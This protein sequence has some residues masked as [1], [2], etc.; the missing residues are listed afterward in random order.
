MS[1]I[2]V[3]FLAAVAHSVQHTP[4]QKRLAPSLRTRRT[5]AWQADL[6]KLNA[7]EYPDA[8]CN[9]GTLAAYYFRPAAEESSA[10]SW[11]I[12]FEGGGECT[13][14]VNC[15]ARLNTQLG[16]SSKF[17]LKA[18][19]QQLV[20]PNPEENP[21]L[22]SWNQVRIKYCSSDLF[23]GTMR[24]LD[25]PEWGTVRFSGYHVVMSVLDHLAKTRELDSASHVVLTGESAGGMAVFAFL[26]ELAERLPQARVVGV[27]IAGYYWDNKINYT[28]A[29]ATSWS[30]DFSDDGFKAHTELWRAHLP[31][32]CT[33]SPDADGRPWVCALP[34]MSFRTL[35]S[36]IFVVEALVD[37]TQLS[38][39]S[40][41]PSCTASS[42][43][44]ALCQD[45]GHTMSASLDQVMQR[46]QGNSSLAGLFAPNCM[47]H[48]A[49]TAKGPLVSGFSFTQ[50]FGDWYKGTASAP[51][52]LK[53]EECCAPAVRNPTCP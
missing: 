1:V 20:S 33:A 29:G 5:A 7:S 51:T 40:H 46:A 25:S 45:F 44:R 28:G 11:V 32:R 52:F 6:V 37:Q 30:I 15:E 31:S 22:H 53:D 24:A 2:W 19:Q 34:H 49:F 23:L 12:S 41:L 9:D 21:D 13:T 18:T 35:E 42:D 10:S 27:P 8:L 16:S 50:A 43:A 4:P 47:M 48:T 26:D 36:P 38:M 3:L 39:H 17:Y 14:Q